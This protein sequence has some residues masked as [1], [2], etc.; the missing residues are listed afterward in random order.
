MA[1][2]LV[3]GGA[4][5]I[6][7]NFVHYWRRRHPEDRIVVLDALTYA[8][9]RASLPDEDRTLRF[10]HGDI[11]DRAAD[12]SLLREE[13]IDTVVHFAA[14]SH[15]DRSIEGPERFVE[16]NVN[17]TCALLEAARR[18]WGDDTSGR[19][20]HHVSTDEV[21]GTLGPRDAAFTEATP[22]APNSPYAASKAAADHLVRAYNET[23]AL[24]VTLSNCSNNYGPYH[25]PEKLIPLF[26]VNLLEGRELPVYGQGT[27]VRDWLHVE[28]HCSG[29][30]AILER[31]TAGRTYNIGSRNEKTNLEVVE[32]LCTAVD[33]A[34]EG[35]GGLAGRFPEAPPAGGKACRERIRFV[36]DRPG[37]DFRYAID[38]TRLEE[39]LEWRPS[40]GFAEGLEATVRW[41]LD[42]EPWWRS[43]LDG[44]GYRAWIE[45]Q[46]GERSG[47]G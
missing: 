31:G 4:G 18:V 12:E 8:G 45:T 37:H 16:V 29:I 17:G 14:E 6:G 33:T 41:Y 46:Y 28:D 27:N 1:R 24:P 47:G 10:V 20:F 22:Y 35:D 11:V 40:V 26:I 21:Y 9:H 19:R 23:Y 7:A 13:A 15:V 39:E 43:I 36:A 3:T 5:F 38:A 42:N 32:Q 2:L 44:G 34:F 30:E 25:Y